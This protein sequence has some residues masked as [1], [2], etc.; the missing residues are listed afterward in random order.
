MNIEILRDYCLSKT[1]A[2]ESFPFGE[3]TLVFKVMNKM[4]ALLPLNNEISR[5]N[6]KTD[7]EWSEELRE[8]YSQIYGAF[9]MNK[10]HWNSV[11]IENGIEYTLITKMVDHSYELVVSKLPK[12]LKE[13]LALLKKI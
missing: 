6:L 10:K 4:F 8:S 9:H 5:V 13:E 1:G 3:D 11:E 12:K 7:P 2:E